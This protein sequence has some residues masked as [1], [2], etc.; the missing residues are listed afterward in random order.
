VHEVEFCILGAIVA[1][2]KDVG[3]HVHLRALL[4]KKEK[5]N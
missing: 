4:E 5:E 2:M 1:G 3:W